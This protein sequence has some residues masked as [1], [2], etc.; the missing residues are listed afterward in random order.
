MDFQNIR[1]EVT[2]TTTRT[3]QNGVDDFT[4]K[5]SDG[6]DEV[7]QTFDSLGDIRDGDSD[8]GDENIRVRKTVTYAYNTND[9]SDDI[10]VNP[11]VH[12]LTNNIERTLPSDWDL[13]NVDLV[14]ERIGTTV[15]SHVDEDLEDSEVD[16]FFG[17]PEVDHEIVTNVDDRMRPPVDS[18]I[19]VN[20]GYHNNDTVIADG[21]ISEEVNRINQISEDNEFGI[22]DALNSPLADSGG[23]I[24]NG[25]HVMGDVR[26]DVTGDWRMGEVEG[27]EVPDDFNRVRD[28][29]EEF[30]NIADDP[31]NTP[32]FGTDININPTS[33]NRNDDMKH[34]ITDEDNSAT[35]DTPEGGVFGTI[36]E[37][38]MEVRSTGLHYA[39]D[40]ITNKLEGASD[41]GIMGTIKHKAK[42]TNAVETVKNK[43]TDASDSAINN[44]GIVDMVKDKM[45]SSDF[46]G[47][48]GASLTGGSCEGEEKSETLDVIGDSPDVISN[49]TNLADDT[50]LKIV[51]NSDFIES[52]KVADTN[53]EPPSNHVHS[54]PPTIQVNSAPPTIQI[55]SEPQGIEIDTFNALSDD[56][57]DYEMKDVDISINNEED[58]GKVFAENRQSMREGQGTELF[59]QPPRFNSNESL[60]RKDKEKKAKKEKEANGTNYTISDMPKDEARSQRTCAGIM[61]S[62]FCPKRGSW[63]PD[64]Y[65]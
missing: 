64:S 24:Q 41:E 40:A 23:F 3:I 7:I 57:M 60:N 27:S 47:S 28:D 51:D 6:E 44:D 1:T 65:L 17:V 42:E 55:N 32:S 61:K 26:T 37:K 48:F 10:N 5:M 25:E 4:S 63:Q 39:G 43:I 59:R 30:T 38:V 19:S 45:G 18:E 54:E 21:L 36:K 52:V 9:I 53:A 15:V 8:N 35:V 20:T 33:E 11:E 46:L 34:E 14:N 16:N 31:A 2:T 56:D 13:D 22:S 58:F 12:D 50:T 62:F 29:V 49:N